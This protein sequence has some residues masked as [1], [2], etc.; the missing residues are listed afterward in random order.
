MPRSGFWCKAVWRKLPNK[1][2]W[3]LIICYSVSLGPFIYSY[4]HTLANKWFN[5]FV[6][7]MLRIVFVLGWFWF[8]IDKMLV[9]SLRC[10]CVWG[11]PVCRQERG[12]WMYIIGRD[13]GRVYKCGNWDCWEYSFVCV[14]ASDHASGWRGIRLRKC[15]YSHK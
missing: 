4:L 9:I 15:Q 5:K 10:L 6:L 11:T 1:F 13:G 14:G 12:W 8:I 2:C 7:D 3:G